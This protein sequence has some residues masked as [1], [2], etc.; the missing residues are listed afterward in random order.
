MADRETY[1]GENGADN[2]EA[3]AA[4]AAPAA[5]AAA[6]AA[7]A[8]AAAA[9]AAAARPSFRG[10]DWSY[11]LE[12]KPVSTAEMT[13]FLEKEHLS[14][15]PP[16]YF[17]K[18]DADLNPTVTPV[19]K[20]YQKLN[21][22][23]LIKSTEL[24]HDAAMDHIFEKTEWEGDSLPKAINALVQSLNEQTIERRGLTPRGTFF[25]S[26]LNKLKDGKLIKPTNKE[27][28]ID[29]DNVE[30]YY[31]KPLSTKLST[32]N[33]QIAGIIIGSVGI[34]NDY[35]RAKRGVRGGMKHKKHFL[36]HKRSKLAKYY[37]KASL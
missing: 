12:D 17:E 14:L 29:F 18:T 2:D 37:I 20:E 1:F 5:A 3:A 26:S 23:I 9:S 6:P 7:A 35:L 10:R 32:K 19:T 25:Y 16:N 27:V 22:S 15:S 31:L 34:I 4:A 30:T 33:K 8:P 13:T 11:G 36:K 21:I 24:L 28:P